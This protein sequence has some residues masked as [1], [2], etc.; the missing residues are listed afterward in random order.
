ML[1]PQHLPQKTL[2]RNDKQLKSPKR[3]KKLESLLPLRMQKELR[4]KRLLLNSKFKNKKRL[5]NKLKKMLMNSKQK[6]M[7][8]LKLQQ[9]LKLMKMLPLLNKQKMKLML[10]N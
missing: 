7:L 3:K 8:M 5:K 6:K 9:M 4:T 10:R 1:Q 2:K